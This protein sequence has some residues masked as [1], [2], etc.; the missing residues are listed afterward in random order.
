[1]TNS[2]KNQSMIN[3]EIIGRGEYTVAQ[4]TRINQLIAMHLS[5]CEFPILAVMVQNSMHDLNYILHDADKIELIDL[6]S[7]KGARIYRRSA[8]FILIKACRELFPDRTVIVRHSM[9]NGIFCE[10]RHQE[11]T[12][13]EVKM[14]EEQMHKIVAS[15][16]LIKRITVNKE[17]AVEIFTAQGQ[18]DLVQLMKQREKEFVHVYELDGFYEYFYGYMVI[19]TGQ[20]DRFRLIN[21][22]PGIVL[23]TPEKKNPGILMPFVEQKKL[24]SIYSEAKAWAE[25]LKA[26]HVAAV[27]EIVSRGEINDFIRV[28]EALHEKKIASIA[29]QI[30][31]NQDVRIILIAGPS[32]SGKTTFAQRL[33]IQLRVNGKEPVAI[34]MDN[35]FVNRCDTPLDENNEY[36]FEALEA[37]KLELFNEHLQQLINGEE[38]EMP[39]YNFISGTCETEG[40]KIKLGAGQPLIL[41]GIHCLN[42]QLTSSIYAKQK[43][44]IYISALTQLNIDY[45]N[46]ISTTDSR[47]IRRIIRDNRTRGHNALDTIKRWPSVRNG[48]EKNIFPFQE[49]ADAMFNSSLVYEL[50]ILKPYIEPLLR[51]IGPENREYAEAKRLLKFL[52]Y[53]KT[54]ETDEIPINSILREFVGNSCFE[55]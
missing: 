7:E 38:V 15:D 33:F 35:Y 23:Q 47:L 22:P 53:F 4:G 36:D 52:S 43:F 54:A 29:D 51:K 50:F 42:D 25:M 31:N 27:N 14:I 18:L 12:P 46:N 1:M 39:V 13:A 49:N 44:K 6:T 17:K 55:H 48:E 8:M 30:C 3:V 2:D 40:V 45:S 20:I 32:S 11:V 5:D 21:Y 26:P 41:E 19:N 10:F 24:S 9:S 34:S 16:L 28:N 37:L